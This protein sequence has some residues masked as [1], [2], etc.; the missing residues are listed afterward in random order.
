MYMTVLRSGTVG[1]FDD[2]C[3]GMAKAEQ[4]HKEG[5]DPDLLRLDI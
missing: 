1:Q 4:F 2:R 5:L 3:W